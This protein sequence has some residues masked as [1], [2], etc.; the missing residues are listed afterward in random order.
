LGKRKSSTKA[1]LQSNIY[2]HLA[3]QIEI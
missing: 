3:R 2:K 1:A